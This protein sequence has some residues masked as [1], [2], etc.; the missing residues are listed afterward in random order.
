MGHGQLLH[1]LHRTAHLEA[2]G[3]D[4]KWC[5]GLLRPEGASFLLADVRDLPF[6]DNAFDTVIASEVL[7][8]LE[9]KDFP[10]GLSELRRVCRRQLILTV[11]FEEDPIWHL[12]EPGGHRQSFGQSK[13]DRLF[14]S[15]AQAQIPRGG[16]SWIMLVEEL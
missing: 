9:V 13:V 2:V 4:Y 3:V 1:M 7:E 14:P 11:P 8:H 10:T 6:K 15:A 5:K 12:N 16:T